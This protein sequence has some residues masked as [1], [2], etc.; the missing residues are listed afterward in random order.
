MIHDDLV[1]TSFSSFFL[2]LVLIGSRFSPSHVIAKRANGQ[3]WE[4]GRGGE[5][6]KGKEV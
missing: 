6:G 1:K 5:K 3:M 4:K 2:L